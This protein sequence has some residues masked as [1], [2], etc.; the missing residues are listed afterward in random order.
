MKHIPTQIAS[1]F[2][3]DPKPLLTA[4][5]CCLVAPF[6]AHA[7]NTFSPETNL[8]AIDQVTVTG[9][10][11]FNDVRATIHS[12]SLLGVDSGVPKANSFDPATALLTLGSVAVDGTTYNNVRVKI[13]THV[14]L[15]A[16]MVTTP[17]AGYTLC[18]TEGQQCNFSGTANVIY[19]ANNTWTSPRSFTDSV[20]CNNSTFG[21]PLMQVLKACYTSTS[22]E[23]PA[24][25]VVPA[26]PPA[27]VAYYFSDCQA[28]AAVGCVPGNNANPGT[29]AAPKQ[30]LTGIDVNNLPAGAA[31]FFNRGGAWNSS[32]TVLENP[33]TTAAAPLVF[34]AYGTGPLPTFRQSS[35]NMFHMGGNWNNTSNDGGYTFRNIKFD[36]LGTATWGFWFVH[37]VRDVVIENSEITGF[38]IGINSNDSDAHGVRGITLRN[39]NIHHNHDMGMLG[40]YNDLLIE[41]NLIEANNFSGSGFSHGTYLGGG[42]NITI[43][44]NRYLRNS[45]VNG[46][47]QGG[48]MT[49]HGQIDGL[50]IEGNRIEQDAAA[51]G[52]WLMSITQGYATAEWF[53]NTVVR[54]NRLINGG[55]NAMNA[56]SAPGI[57][58]EGNVIINTNP[59]YQIGISVGHTDYPNGDLPDGNATVRNNTVC[60]SGGATGPA[61]NVTAPNSVVTNNVVV[62]GTAATTGV[63]AR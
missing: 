49:F 10:G 26:T 3:F 45:V 63:C 20:S 5:A 35:G 30:N 47:C 33:Q 19:G 43:R 28:G 54:N 29:Q 8:L 6:G 1:R 48:N 31:L 37:T 14:F 41:G 51:G 21:D 13:N 46:V 52:C 24:T 42:N 22:A 32:T 7:M 23:P 40:H 38:A 15:S 50:L 11:V 44:N 34:D 9:L 4:M 27:S 56:Q 53:R 12:Y 39:N 18:A 25:P 61:T 2:L 16:P 55:N 62:T 36:G 17:P 58:V 59:T 60:Q 57:L